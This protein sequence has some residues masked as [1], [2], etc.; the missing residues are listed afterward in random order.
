[1][2]GKKKSLDTCTIIY[3]KL[4]EMHHSGKLSHTYI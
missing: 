4:E 2:Y 3:P 1:M